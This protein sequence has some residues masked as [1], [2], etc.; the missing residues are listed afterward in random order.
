M[1]LE[2]CETTTSK[3][4]EN[5][6]RRHPRFFLSAP[7]VAR[8]AL[9]AGSHV[10]RGITVDISLGGLSAVLCGPPRIGERVS[11]RM[12]LMNSA[13]EAPAV[14]RHSSSARTGFEFLSLPP[15]SRCTIE[16]CIR[17]S[18]LYP[19]PNEAEIQVV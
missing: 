1:Q 4:R 8:R 11:L 3:S 16:K 9:S 6:E 14:V 19:L 12:K 10:T 15:E 17:R 5:T 2:S 13:F 7:M 18:L